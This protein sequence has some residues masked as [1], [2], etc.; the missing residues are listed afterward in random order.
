MP[1]ECVLSRMRNDTPFHHAESELPHVNWW[2]VHYSILAP[3][4]ETTILPAGNSRTLDV[5]LEVDVGCGNGTGLEKTS[6]AVSTALSLLPP[7]LPRFVDSRIYSG[8]DFRVFVSFRG[9]PTGRF[10]LSACLRCQIS[11][12]PSGQD[13]II[14]KDC[15]TRM[16]ITIPWAKRGASEADPLECLREGSVRHLG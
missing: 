7:G 3:R 13:G 8:A 2:N 10:F 6:L 11:T 16:T 12:L 5:I 4:E 9:G 14:A 1:A 15:K